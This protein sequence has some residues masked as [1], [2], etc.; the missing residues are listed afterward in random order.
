MV[1]LRT[2]TAYSCC[3]IIALLATGLTGRRAMNMVAATE[4]APGTEEAVGHLVGWQDWEENLL[5][6][7][8][9]WHYLIPLD[10]R[11]RPNRSWLFTTA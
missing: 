7:F 6:G 3:T 1:R 4:A 10:S 5:G 11:I 8:S 9:R 2:A